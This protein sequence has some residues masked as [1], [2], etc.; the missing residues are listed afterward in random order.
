MTTTI[1]PTGLPAGLLASFNNKDV[2]AF[3][4]DATRIGPARSELISLNIPTNFSISWNFSLFEFQVFEGWYKNA[5]RKG[6]D[7][8]LMYLSVGKGY[9]Q[10]E[11][12][13]TDSYSVS[14]IGKRVMV[15]VPI[16]AIAKQFNTDDEIDTLIELGEMTSASDQVDW[17]NKFINFGEVVLP[18]A[19]E[20]LTYGTDYS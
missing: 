5:I 17:F 9:S 10:H 8:F 3:S 2:K 6:S 15:S 14:R 1:Y 18:D 12:I 19:W 13:F 7:P 20:T 4:T 11:C 16:M